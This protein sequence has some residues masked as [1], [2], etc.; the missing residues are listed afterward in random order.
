MKPTKPGEWWW[1]MYRNSPIIVLIGKQ[2]EGCE[3]LR[4]HLFGVSTH[5]DTDDSSFVWL[6]EVSPPFAARAEPVAPFAPSPDPAAP[7]ASDETRLAAGW[8]IEVV[9][10]FEADD[11]SENDASHF[12]DG[13]DQTPVPGPAG[14]WRLHA[15][16]RL[17]VRWVV[18]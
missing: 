18:S 10:V 15:S 11:L 5:G 13:E 14:E 12:T 17:W 8:V 1:C 16:G 9:P 4:V 2:I 6:H 7:D 3:A